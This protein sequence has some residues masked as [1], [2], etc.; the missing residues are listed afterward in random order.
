MVPF[1]ALSVAAA[2]S[3]F[4]EAESRSWRAVL[5][6]FL[7]GLA[8]GALAYPLLWASA[9]AWRIASCS[10]PLTIAAAAAGAGLAVAVIVVL[11][12]YTPA[13]AA[14]T[15]IYGGAVA[16]V[17]VALVPFLLGLPVAFDYYHR[18]TVFTAWR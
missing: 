14:A 17:C 6:W 3:A 7:A 13:R 4:R 18:L 15:W 8:A 16:G 12:R 9:H 10:L 2:L 5:G 1:L 11:A